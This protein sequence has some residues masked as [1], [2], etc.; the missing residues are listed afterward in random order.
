MTT[1]SSRSLS[2]RRR[3]WVIGLD[4]A[5]LGFLRHW[6][7]VFNVLWGLFVALPWLAPVLMQTGQAGVAGIIY[8]AYSTQ[9]HQLPQR[10]YFLFGPQTTYS[11]TEVQA[12]WQNTNNPYILRQFVGNEA[13]G[14]KVAW[15][16]RMV[17]MYTSILVAGLAFAF[18]RK[19]L[20]PMPIWAFAVFVLPMVLDGGTHLVSD[21][22][23]IGHG[24][25]DSNDWLAVLTGRAFP[26][27]FYAGD[28][29]GSFNSW[30]RLITG[31]LFGVAVVWLAY[32]YLEEA[33]R[34]S[35]GELEA[36]LRGAGALA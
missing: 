1:S 28:T 30:L 36:K 25:R 6:L 8:S 4:R 5:I 10:S 14:W 29:F 3:A 17:S 35:A 13:M 27:W 2:P 9:C 32:P 20:R 11:L 15:S 16:D 23:G 26:L 24:F 12:A 19:R 18:I 33:L 7:L 22:A 34:E 21:L 31:L